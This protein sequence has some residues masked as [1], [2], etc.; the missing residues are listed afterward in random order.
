MHK[1]LKGTI[2]WL[3]LL[4]LVYFVTRLVNLT[5]LP[6][7]TDEAIYIRWSQIGGQD[8]AWRFISL[9][10]GKQPLFTWMVMASLRV[11]QDPLFAGRFVSVVAGVVSIIGLYFLAKEIFRKKTVGVFAGLLY[12]I[13]PFALM[14]DRLALYDAWVAAFSIW[15]LYFAILLVRKIRLDIALV[16][17]WTLGL[18]MLNKTSA[19]FSLYLLPTTLILFDWKDRT[20]KRKLLY[21]FAY[22]CIAGILSQVI[23]S[24][25]R[26]SPFFYIISQ[27]DALFVYPFREWIHHP[28]TFLQGNWRGLFNWLYGY[29]TWPILIAAYASFVLTGKKFW[30]KLLLFGWWLGPFLALALFGR[31]LYPRFILFMTMPLFILAASSFDALFS[32]F[33]RKTVSWIFILLLCFQSIYISGRVLFDIKTAPIVRAD[34]GQLISD[35]PSGWGTNEVVGFLA[36][37]AKK[38]PLAIYSEGTFGLFPYALEIYLVKNPNI[39]IHGLWP[40]P[41]KIPQDMVQSATEKPTYFVSNFTQT[42]PDWPMQL[43]DVYPKANNYSVAMRLY[44]LESPKK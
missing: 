24:I 28:F 2:V 3:L 22:V 32:V 18:G 15:N 12:L 6:I 39:E 37:E 21:W 29:M 9:T 13:S 23:Y 5:V 43:L 8:A 26:L 25:L 14:Y 11:F 30:E 4:T 38:G 44:R 42:K 19:F 20:W 1:F 31:V 27:K 7:F 17:A 41:L 36:D 10:D 34:I 35:W 40:L 33:K 16:L